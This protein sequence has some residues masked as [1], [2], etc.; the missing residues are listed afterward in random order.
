MCHGQPINNPSW[1]VGCS[2]EVKL[3]EYKEGT[4]HQKTYFVELWD[5]GGSSSLDMKKCP[6]VAQESSTPG[7]WECDDVLVIC[8]VQIFSRADYM[9]IM[10]IS[11][12]KKKTF[13]VALDEIRGGM[14]KKSVAKKYNIPRSTLQ[15]RLTAKFSKSLMGPAPDEET[16]LVMW[17]VY[18]TTNQRK[19]PFKENMPCDGVITCRRWKALFEEKESKK[20]EKEKKESNSFFDFIH[21]FICLNNA[22]IPV[23]FPLINSLQDGRAVRVLVF[24]GKMKTFHSFYR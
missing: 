24:D 8:T 7:L 18:L 4:P 13:Y 22:Q 23:I 11:L 9:A 17:I 21:S 14:S 3:H 6:H 10:K 12:E 20:K 15:F 1:T 5:I 2:V 19:T 16:L